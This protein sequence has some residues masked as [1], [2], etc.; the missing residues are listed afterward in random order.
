MRFDLVFAKKELWKPFKNMDL[1]L[2]IH[3]TE[4]AVNMNRPRNCLHSYPWQN[5]T[6][7]RQQ[8]LTNLI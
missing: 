3:N 6:E 5:M 7:K 4:F 2:V 1:N 8:E